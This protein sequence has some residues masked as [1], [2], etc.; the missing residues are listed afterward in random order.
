LAGSGAGFGTGGTFRATGGF[1]AGGGTA[2]GLDGNAAAARLTAFSTFAAAFASAPTTG[3]RKKHRQKSGM[4]EVSAEVEEWYASLK[5]RDKAAADRHLQIVS[6]DFFS[7]NDS[8]PGLGQ[9]PEFMQSSFS[10]KPK[11][12]PELAR[13]PQG[14]AIFEMTDSKPATTPTFEEARQRVEAEF[15]NQQA[16]QL[17]SKKTQ[18]L[19][20]RARAL[21]DLKR[22]AKEE[23]ATL[24]KSELVTA[25]SQVP[26]LGSMSGSAAAAFELSK[27]Q[28][29]GP[30]YSGKNGAVLEITEQQEPSQA[31]YE[32]GKQVTRDAVLE[33]KRNEVFTVYAASLKDQMEKQGKIKYNK[34]EQE[35]MAPARNNPVGS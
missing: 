7:Q 35:R 13:T 6:S 33:R 22:A 20:E 9:A 8:L 16:Q 34:D 25:Q 29:S 19:S 4:V 17:L 14:Y 26:D 21:H 15:R 1:T 5:S 3:S 12:A 2:A 11:S 31:E 24:K 27:G 10:G 30:I 28:V 23:G 18:E 32:K